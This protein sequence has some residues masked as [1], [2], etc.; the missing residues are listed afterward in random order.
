MDL[1]NKVKQLELDNALKD[2]VINESLAFF[3][4][5][6]ANLEAIGIKKDEIRAMS[7]DPALAAEEKAWILDQIRYINFLREDNARKV[8]QMNKEIESNGIKIKELEVMVESLVNEIKWKDEQIHLLETEL[9]QLDAE[10]SK[11][12]NAYQEQ[13]I[14]IDL[15]TA[16]L[17]TVYY[18]YGSEKELKSNGVIEKKNG[19]IGIGKKLSLSDQM[20]QD[21]FTKIDSQKKTTITMQGKKP[22]FI[23]SHPTS[24]YEMTDENGMITIK[25]LDASEFWKVSKYLVVIVS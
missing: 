11:L 10:Y 14:E 1:Q 15:L 7:D 25:I 6:Q 3:N 17:N 24:S 8:Q 2:S 16:D 13:A 19:F 5:I 18:A 20:N 4:E 21:Y 22:H 23:T 9:N 12:F